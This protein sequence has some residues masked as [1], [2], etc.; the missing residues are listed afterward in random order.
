MT[1]LLLAVGFFTV[2]G[3]EWGNPGTLGPLDPAGKLLA[4]L[5]P[6]GAAAHGGLQHRRLRADGRDDSARSRTCSCSSVPGAPRPGAGSRWRRSPCSCSWSGRRSRG[7]PEVNV[8]R[9]PDQRRRAAAGACGEPD[10]IRG[11]RHLHARPRGRQRRQRVAEHL[12][13]GLGV[14]HGRAVDRDHGRA[15]RGRD[16]SPSSCSCTWAVS[17]R[18][19]SARRSSLRERRRRYRYAEGRPIIG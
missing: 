3:F 15:S 10:R 19:R 14:R 17:A 12:R 7:D 16:R 8:V 5:L 18:M 13:V 1:G 4:S 6:G 11:G 2:L 9:P